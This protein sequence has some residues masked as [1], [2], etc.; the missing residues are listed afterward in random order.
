MSLLFRFGGIFVL[1]LVLIALLFCAAI[2]NLCVNA[3][4]IFIKDE[5]ERRRS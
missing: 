1:I 3:F 5:D 2:W 4:A